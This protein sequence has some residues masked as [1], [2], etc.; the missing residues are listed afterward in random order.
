MT[1]NRLLSTLTFSL[2]FASLWLAFSIGHAVATSYPDKMIFRNL[3]ESQDIGLG[4]V[5]AII[6]DTDGFMWFGGRNGLL[7]FDGYDFFQVKIEP[8]PLDEKNP[9]EVSQTIDL[10]V[11]SNGMLWVATRWG[12]YQY[13]REREVLIR[14]KT[15][16]AEVN[17]NQGD[18]N[19]IVELPSGAMMVA[20]YDGLLEIDSRTMAATRIR[21]T[22]AQDGPIGDRIHDLFLDVNGHLWMGADGGISRFDPSTRQ[23]EHFIVFKDNPEAPKE[24]SIQTIEGDR[25]G[26]I[27]A[28]ASKGLYR[29]IPETKQIFRYM[30]DPNE[31]NSISDDIHE[32]LF[33]DSSGILWIGTDRGGLNYYRYEDDSFRHF[34]NN[35][36]E[37]GSISSNITRRIYEDNNRDLWVGTYPSGI[38]FHDR[39]S[40]AISVY[41]HEGGNANS[42][43]VDLVT[44]IQEDKLGNL[45]IGT[46][47]GGP[48]YLDRSSGQF[49]KYQLKLDGT[50]K[51]GSNKM[52]CGL[53]DS[54]G[55]VWFGTWDA[56]VFRYN[57]K[58][59]RFDQL[60]LDTS[61]AGGNTTKNVL[62]DTSIWD[63][64]EDSASTLWFATHNAGLARYDEATGEF[65]YYQEDVN[66]RESLSN[67]LVWTVRE[68]A[69]G[70]FWVGTVGGLNLMDRKAGTFKS[71]RA[72]G[73]SNGS[74]K[75]DF[76]TSIFDDAQGRLWVGTN[77]GL[78]LF[79]EQDQTF[80]V[81]DDSDGFSDNGIRS[82]EQDADGDLW[83]GTNNGIIVF[84]PDTL[85]VKNHRR[86]NGDKI[87]GISTGGSLKTAQGELIFGGPNGMRIYNLSKLQENDVP[88]PVV[89]TDFRIFT[90]PVPID[91]PG[92]FLDKAVNLA[93]EITLTH[94]ESMIS[95]GYAALNFRDSDK[96]QYA[97]KLEGFDE[98]WREVGPLRQ[99]LYTNL[100]AGR[101]TF[102][103][104]ASNNDGIWNEEG[105]SIKLRQL[106]PPWLTWWAITLYVLAVIAVVARF[107]YQQH[108]KRIAIE[109]QNRLLEI[110]VAERTSEL[111]A[112]NE[113]IQS[114]LSNM[115]QG[116]FTIDSDG[117]VQPE[118]SQHLETIFERS[119]LAGIQ[120][121][122][123]LFADAKL[124]SNDLNQ[125]KEAI[126]AIIGEGEMNFQFNKHLLTEEYNTAV[127]GIAKCLTLD[128]NPI[129]DGQGRVKKLMVSVRDV[130]LLKQM[131]SEA[132][133]KKRELDI[134][135]QLLNLSS[136]KYRRFIDSCNAF[137]DANKALIECNLS[138][139]TEVLSALF[140]NMHTIKGNCR[141]FGFT[142]FSDV[143]HEV[144]SR[145]SE[146]TINESS[147]WDKEPLLA[148]IERVRAVLQ[149]Y[150]HVFSSVLG[151]NRGNGGRKGKGFWLNEEIIKAIT[152]DIE[153]ALNEFPAPSSKKYLENIRRVMD[154]GLS[155]TLT[156]MLKDVIESLPSMAA[157]LEKAAPN[158]IVEDR[159]VRI[160][161]DYHETFNNVFAHLLRNCVDHGI[162]SPAERQNHGKPPAG[163]ITL[164]AQM[165][166]HF[167]VLRVQ[168]DG[169]GIHLKK[170]FDIGQAKGQWLEDTMP[171][172][173]ELC[174]TL[175]N[176]GVSTKETLSD[177]SG[178]GVG[179]DAVRQFVRDLG[180]DV[181]IELSDDGGGEFDPNN[182]CYAAAQ[183][184]LKLPVAVCVQTK[185]Q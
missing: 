22:G 182:T 68:D 160:K 150:E 64:Y 137:L 98:H 14:L 156:D 122:D 13:S 164:S 29:I 184:V 92:G 80:T 154:T 71:Y 28:G 183:F 15:S 179:M 132:A 174:E 46:D 94:K 91:G 126:F 5:E 6:Q 169:R 128:W 73:S 129:V 173:M 21:A 178:R 152:Q 136:E 106:P 90:K 70:R 47:G 1:S 41:K 117:S 134:I 88:P 83:L 142:Y 123:L 163:T 180:G 55:D 50:S 139:N 175:F 112:K 131:E 97:Y 115:R 148:D 8:D 130:T 33:L 107:I 4:E 26:H 17:F 30:S 121:Y 161:N 61:Q 19:R 37:K 78:H 146:L 100:G 62:I 84:N 172:T 77:N 167:L 143:V 99:A 7:R 144:E 67:N 102:R 56:G 114:M 25:N 12:L 103:V 155:S 125:I 170:L 133:S 53:V 35:E 109:E 24:N 138:K 44:D 101:Y 42:L 51:I 166:E 141:T 9:V 120:A 158:V 2:R 72:D 147:L 96:N 110:R 157:Q 181:F 48:A 171:T 49:T 119:E 31:P 149:E 116:L 176:S 140:R 10:F 124:G 113:D 11:D 85:D 63:I 39:S 177:I 65:T 118:Y 111:H 159:G 75:N 3:M 105:S 168:D 32:D 16:N 135:S 40:S 54:N 69:R 82:I 52:L 153:Q 23:F 20:T 57:A 76:I 104:R 93:E 18:F 34:R 162:E 59:D 66:N 58:A 74:L 89:L 108:R 185:E 79:N 151:R 165:N 43:P 86:F 145:Y 36:G 81:Y 38:N 45:W 95:F 127:R 87:G 27:W 60:P